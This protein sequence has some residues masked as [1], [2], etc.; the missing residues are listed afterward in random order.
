M[1]GIHVNA[2][3]MIVILLNGHVSNHFDTFIYAHMIDVRGSTKMA[4]SERP[5]RSDQWG[6]RV[7]VRFF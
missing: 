2:N 7:A 4:S 5:F 3:I 1:K 6:R